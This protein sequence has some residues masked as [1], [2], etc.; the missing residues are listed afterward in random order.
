L[1]PSP[2]HLVAPVGPHHSGVAAARP[3]QPARHSA[4]RR[5]RTWSPQR[6]TPPSSDYTAWYA[7]DRE[8]ATRPAARSPQQTGHGAT[9]TATV[10]L[11][12]GV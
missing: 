2:R 11:A 7:S 4:P 3:L 8:R 1:L 10:L 9:C 5:V 12:P 6:L